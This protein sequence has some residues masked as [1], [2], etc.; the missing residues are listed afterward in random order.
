MA[1]KFS[2]TI[3][4]SN[5]SGTITIK[6]EGSG[7]AREGG[8]IR[9][10]N[11]EGKETVYLDGD[12]CNLVLG[13]RD[14]GAE[15]AGV[16]LHDGDGRPAIRVEGNGHVLGVKNDNNHDTV[17]M[18]GR[19]GSLWLG[20]GGQ[21]GDLFLK[22]AG[23]Q[24]A[25]H[26]DGDNANL[27]MGGWGSGGNIF[28]REF[29]GSETIHIDGSTGDIRLTNADCAEDFDVAA[30]TLAEPGTVMVL[31]NDARLRP[32]EQPYDR[33]VAGVV[34]GAGEYRPAI[35]LDRHGDAPGRQPIALVG[36]V[37]CKVDA[38]QSPVEVGDLLTTSSTPG[39]AM[40]ADPARAAG[41]VIGKAM[42]PL[43]DGKGLVS[44][45]ISLQ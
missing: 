19:L 18:N 8:G 37:Y 23:G 32:S 20:G 21:G 11:E 43:R 26:L 44:I 7:G 30:G 13:S 39:H 6:L 36:K 31:D 33:R 29:G 1:E 45:L 22:K 12:F 9:L 14:G 5:S 28:L 17:H 2:G 27:T 16:Y 10:Y 3:E 42:R 41:A 34:S 40:K 25:V 35:V 15:S 24:D 38:S 4:V